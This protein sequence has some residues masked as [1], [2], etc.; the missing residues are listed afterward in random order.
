MIIF[1]NDI[2][3]KDKTSSACAWF[4]A[5]ILFKWEPNVWPPYPILIGWQPL[6]WR[7]T[8][9]C[10]WTDKMEYLKDLQIPEPL[11][12]IWSLSLSPRTILAIHFNYIS[13]LSHKRRSASR[14][15]SS[16]LFVS[17]QSCGWR[18]NLINCWTWHWCAI[19]ILRVNSRTMT[20]ERMKSTRKVFHYWILT[21]LVT[22]L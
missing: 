19:D 21:C 3:N 14:P 8:R 10:R 9:S 5:N 7:K 4:H 12:S 13:I 18:R 16:L 20:M 2:L 1:P 17:G 15:H 6:M 22:S 11:P